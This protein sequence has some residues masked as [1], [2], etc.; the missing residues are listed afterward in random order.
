[1]SV[2]VAIK[3]DGKIYMGADTMVTYGGSKRYLTTPHTQKVWVVEDTPNC[4]MGC[5]GMLSD[6]NLVRYCGQ[7]LVPEVAALKNEVNIGVLIQATV[8]KL[9]GLIQEYNDVCGKDEDTPMQSSFIIGVND[10]LFAIYSDGSV[11]EEEEWVAI[12]SGADMALASLENSVGEDPYVRIVKALSSAARISLYVD[13]PYALV[14]NSDL[15]LR[16][17]SYNDLLVEDDEEEEEEEVTTDENKNE[18]EK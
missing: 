13:D 2:V 18:K 6:L 16:I 5:V 10:H 8:P 14:D 11:E 12:G 17:L 7:H 4:I 1:M 9:F 3:E 15:E